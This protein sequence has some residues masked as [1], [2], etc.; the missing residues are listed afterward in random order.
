VTSGTSLSSLSSQERG[1]LP[2]RQVVFCTSSD[3]S[4][5]IK[6]LVS[7]KIWAIKVRWSFQQSRSTTLVSK[8]ISRYSLFEPSKVF[9]S[10]ARRIDAR[11]QISVLTPE[12]IDVIVLTH[13][14]IHVSVPISETICFVVVQLKLF[15]TYRTFYH[16]VRGVVICKSCRIEIAYTRATSSI[17]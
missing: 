3:A 4:N 6:A 8:F 2:L 15:L 5:Q 14:T 11:P 9:A 12:I 10:K 7:L 1:W 13:G 16:S 17:R